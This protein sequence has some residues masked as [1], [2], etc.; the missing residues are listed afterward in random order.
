[1]YRICS[2]LVRLSKQG[3]VTDKRKDTTLQQHLFILHKLQSFGFM[4]SAWLFKGGLEY[5]GSWDLLSFAIDT[6]HNDQNLYY[7]YLPISQ[8]NT[9]C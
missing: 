7:S 4:C 2:K 1:M 6:D 9:F 3:K 5:L 8:Q